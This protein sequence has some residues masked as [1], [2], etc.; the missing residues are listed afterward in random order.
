MKSLKIENFRGFQSFELQQLGRINLLVG[1][2]NSGKTSILEA[3]QLLQLNAPARVFAEI[4]ANRGEFLI[5]ESQKSQIELDVRHLFHGHQIELG[6]GFTITKNDSHQMIVSV[7]RNLIED[8]S[9]PSGAYFQLDSTYDP[10]ITDGQGFDLIVKRAGSKVKDESDARIH[11]TKNLRIS[12][13]STNGNAYKA[14]RNFVRPSSLKVTDIVKLFDEIVLTPDEEV[15]YEALRVIEPIKRIAPV[16]PQFFNVVELTQLGI[17]AQFRGGFDILHESG[18]RLPIGSMG[19]GIWHILG[20]VLSAIASK[21]RILLVDEIDSG[22]HFRAMLGMW[23]VIWR[24]VEKLNIQVFATTHSR[25]CWES[26]AELA[27][28]ESVAEDKITIHR[29]ERNRPRSAVFDAE[30]AVIAANQ[31]IEVR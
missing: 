17:P 19:D 15:V 23:K 27:E 7:G 3:I 16:T 21:K 18:E 25:D 11:L 8:L 1:E 2:N 9:A 13:P 28:S 5:T 4:C 22:L 29:I 31:G 24:I 12:M 6:T 10:P 26:L 14:E 20:L 30:M